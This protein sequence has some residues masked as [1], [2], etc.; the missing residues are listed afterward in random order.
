MPRMNC[1][2]T[3]P[4]GYVRKRFVTRIG[5]KCCGE[6]YKK[7]DD[8]GIPLDDYER[9]RAMNMASLKSRMAADFP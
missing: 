1:F 6:L 2:W 8:S 9:K 7:N 5:C 4:T 3:E